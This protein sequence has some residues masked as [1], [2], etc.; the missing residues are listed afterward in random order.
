MNKVGNKIIFN[1]LQIKRGNRQ[2]SV[3][4]DLVKNLTLFKTLQ[5]DNEFNEIYNYLFNH[6]STK[7]YI[8]ANLFPNN[9]NIFA[10]YE[11]VKFSNKAKYELR[12]HIK[13]ISV[14]QETINAFFETKMVIDELILLNEYEKA[15]EFLN[16]LENQYGLSYWLLE[17]KIFLW[18]KLEKDTQTE[19]IEKAEKGILSTIL[20][21]YDMRSSNE[22]SSRDYNYF[23][24]RE[25]L[26]FK[27]LNPDDKE[28]IAFYHYMIAPFSFVLD[29]ENFMYILKYI[30]KLSLIDRYLCIIDLCEY[31]LIKT[32]DIEYK[33]ELRKY[34]FQ[35]DGI[36]DPCINVFKFILDTSENRID[37]YEIVD[38]L[39]PIKN[40]YITGDIEECYYDIIQYIKGNIT[41]IAAY[42]LYI[43][44]CQILGK[45][46]E[47]LDVSKNI[48]MILK[49]LNSIYSIDKNYNNAL[50]E[51]YKLCFS[52][53]HSV[54]SRD[55]YNF[56]NSRCRPYKDDLQKVALRYKNFQKL[57]IETV[58]ENLEK[59]DALDYLE[60]LE[61][62]DNIYIEFWK[63]FIVEN[64]EE[65]V[66]KCGLPALKTLMKLMKS[67]DFSEFRKELS[68]SD[69]I[70]PVYKIRYY[71][72]LW[73]NMNYK[74]YIEEGIDYFLH[75]FIQREEIVVIAPMEKFMDYFL[76]FDSADKSNLRVPILYYIYTTYFNSSKRDDL[77]IACEDF[78]H[79]NNIEYPSRMVDIDEK[80][81]KE[82]LIFFLRYVC[83]PQL[84]GP[85][86][87]SIRSSRELDQERINTCQNL[88]LLDPEN[89]EEYEQEIR[90]ITQKL[91]INEGLNSI[92][93]SKIHVNTEG[94]KSIISKSLKSDFNNY[95]Y[96]RNHKIDTLLKEIKKIEGGE[97]LQIITFDA[98][99]IFHEIVKTI[100]NEFVSSGEYG[101]DGYLSLNIRHGTLAA[102]LRSPLAKNDLLATYM[103]EESS[104]EVNQKWLNKVQSVKETDAIKTA[105]IEFNK[106][107]D[108]IIEY[109][110]KNLIQISTEEKP[111]SGVFDYE[112][113]DAIIK[114]L[115]TWLTE[116]YEFEEFIDKIFD[117]FW[118]ITEKNLEAMRIIIRDEIKQKYIHSF[119]KL[120]S[121]I[122]TLN[123]KYTFPE[124]LRWLNE[125][126]NDIDAELEKV[127]NW[128][129]RSAESQHADFDLDL[130]FQIG[131][132]MIEN[133]HPEK[134]FSVRDLN[135]A[136][137]VKI[138]GKFMKN[139]LDIFYTLFDNLSEYALEENGTKYISCDL[140][141]DS[142]GT[143]IRMT[144]AFDCS[145][146]I[147]QEEVKVKKALDLI[148]GA[149]YLAR[150]K[151]EGGSGIPKI[152]KILSIDLDKKAEIKCDFSSEKNQFTIEIMGRNK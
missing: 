70:A 20:S 97:N 111:S 12:W 91:V 136:L 72:I 130:A 76:L 62:V 85:V 26:K 137:T 11:D 47:D 33:N 88:R 148:S 36:I 133:I 145:N 16:S 135:K 7:S 9:M 48:K 116:N 84:M 2:K 38:T 37:K 121:V 128:F 114:A 43:D 39:M 30:H 141:V 100:R 102:Q 139:Y 115:Q 131:L 105:I 45:I 109:L 94:I 106:E 52:C 56:I 142:N 75:L 118:D 107:T 140:K 95:M 144:N 104:F 34:I 122:K 87:L 96:Y 51:V 3:R 1:N 143:Y 99:Q 80:Y 17:N 89:E 150:A 35:I 13:T 61:N 92:E 21:F 129:R 23:T 57:T 64:Y 54:W 90:D 103:I 42:N 71:N 41:N 14:H 31:I 134:N 149:A 78:F 29:D 63:V 69:K 151:Q 5:D 66:E 49:N 65:A 25:I 68:E 74:T 112:L 77:S 59:N 24:R 146:G 50:E 46:P 4:T 32:E 58:C 127:S 120:F 123:E 40:K 98:S 79:Y 108:G 15:L 93:N 67:N 27:R 55:I 81:S 152:C 124:A 86:L 126:Q 110:R 44:V 125:S 6:N 101:L 138:P 113:T 8:N 22:V 83:I 117:Y 73:Y 53:I 18:N 10:H 28:I 19:I 132:K 60:K 82:E 147:E 119:S